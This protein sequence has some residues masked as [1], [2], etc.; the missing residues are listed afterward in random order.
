MRS[1]WFTFVGLFFISTHAISIHFRE[2]T[3]IDLT[4]GLL[5]DLNLSDDA[6]SCYGTCFAGV[7]QNE[8]SACSTV[9]VS[10]QIEACMCAQ[11]GVISAVQN[12]HSICLPKNVSVPPSA[13]PQ[14][15]CNEA[16]REHLSFSTPDGQSNGARSFVGSAKLY[17]SMVLFFSTSW[18]L[19]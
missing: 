15:R 5:D 3:P 4:R 11:P 19:A 12:C 6:K 13:D 2:E 8:G 10:L 14:A 1:W 18:T 9:H 17:L 16:S 7:A